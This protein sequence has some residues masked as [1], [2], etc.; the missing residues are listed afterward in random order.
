MEPPAA[1]GRPCLQTQPAEPP[2]PRHLHKAFLFFYCVLPSRLT[3]QNPG[4]LPNAEKW[5]KIEHT[6]IVTESKQEHRFQVGAASAPKPTQKG[7]TGQLR[8]GRPHRGGSPGQGVHIT[9]LILTDEPGQCCIFQA[10]LEGS[11]SPAWSERDNDPTH[12]GLPI[13]LH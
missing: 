9:W 1:Q 8:D 6:I 13:S 3:K 2:A 10:H 12:T 11:F 7:N 5:L 4:R